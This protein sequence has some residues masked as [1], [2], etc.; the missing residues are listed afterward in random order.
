MT[1]LISKGEF[2][3]LAADSPFAF[4]ASR[5]DLDLSILH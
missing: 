2:T 1:L 4:A 5:N 3:C